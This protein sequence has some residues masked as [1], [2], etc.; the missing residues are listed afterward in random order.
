[1]NRLIRLYNQNREFII[2]GIIIIALIVI[3]IQTLNSFVKE[4]KQAKL[5]NITNDTN[6]STNSTTISQSNVSVITGE[7]VK[8]N[9]QYTDVI[10]RFVDYCNGGK[11]ELAY[12]MLTDDCKE[13]VFQSV[14]HFKTSYV[15]KI[16]NIYRMYELKNWYKNGNLITYYIKYTEDVLAT[17]NVNSKNNLGDYITVTQISNKNCLNINSYIGSE[18]INKSE[19]KDGLTVT[20]DKIHMYMDYTTLSLKLKNSEKDVACIDTKEATETIYLYDTNGVKYTAFL[21]E[22]SE[23]E[24]KVRRG[25][26]NKINIKFNKIYNPISREINGI[27][28]KDIV[29]NYENYVAKTE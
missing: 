2:A 16:F 4:E 26:E 8:N 7:T 21:N 10:K 28:L 29:L 17:G 18:K 25:I 6:S 3:I 22:I 20:V 5:N 15:D 24:L 14:S 23:E 27:V 19:T 11:I 9:E 12:D 1:M 13:Q